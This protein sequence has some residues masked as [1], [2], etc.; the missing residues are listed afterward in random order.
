MG[1]KR[2]WLV[3]LLKVTLEGAEFGLAVVTVRVDQVGGR[4]EVFLQVSRAEKRL[5]VVVTGLREV[6]ERLTGTAPIEEEWP[7]GAEAER[8]RRGAEKGVG[9]DGEAWLERGGS[10]RGDG[11]DEAVEGESDE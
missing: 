9:A 6:V 10:D 2:D 11:G 4:P 5:Q 1:R 3:D 7:G 8:L